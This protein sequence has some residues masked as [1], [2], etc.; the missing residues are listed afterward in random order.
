MTKVD[1][2]PL[3]NIDLLALIRTISLELENRECAV[4]KYVEREIPSTVDEMIEHDGKL[5]RKVD[6]KACEGDYIRP[7]VESASQALLK[8]CIYGPVNSLFKVKDRDGITWDCYSSRYSR[9]LV[10]VDVFEVANYVDEI[11]LEDNPVI[12]TVNQQRA[13]LIQRAREFYWSNL[14]GQHYLDDDSYVSFSNTNGYTASHDIDFVVNEEKRT[15][16]ALIK[17][18]G[19]VTLRGIAKYMPGDVFNEWIG[20]AIALA[21]ALKIRIP[22]EFAD[23]VQPVE[24]VIGMVVIAEEHKD[25]EHIL[26]ASGETLRN[27]YAH[28]GS[29]VGKD[30]K[31]IDDTNAEYEFESVGEK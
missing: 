30:G 22:Q 29:P 26:I 2:K 15:V 5:L 12:L 20:K 7:T 24:K 6:R 9:T 31:I 11:P 18:A 16:V 14:K 3:T 19:K 10:T 17:F 21:R 4:T 1:V 8:D 13:E 23:A 25:G 28:I 27:G